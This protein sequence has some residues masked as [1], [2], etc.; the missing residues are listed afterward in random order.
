MR[1]NQCEAVMINGIGPVH[2]TGCKNS[3][4]RYDADSDTWIKQRVCF[5]CGCTVD[6]EDL[7]CAAIDEDEEIALEERDEELADEEERPAPS[8]L[9]RVDE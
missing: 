7:C 9:Q 6:E 1:C 5:D 4:S 2:E 8:W 3:R